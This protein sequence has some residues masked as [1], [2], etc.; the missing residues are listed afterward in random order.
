MRSANLGL[1]IKKF[2]DLGSH[3]HR[4]ERRRGKAGIHTSARH[5]GT[6]AGDGGAMDEERLGRSYCIASHHIKN[7]KFGS[8]GEHSMVE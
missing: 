8:M 1:A 5:S 6:F 2:R 4:I 3:L 7:S